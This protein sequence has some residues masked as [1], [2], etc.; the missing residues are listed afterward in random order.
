MFMFMFICMH[1]FKEVSH[2]IVKAKMFPDLVVC[3]SRSSRKAHGI[4]SS[5]KG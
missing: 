5:T 2:A 4:G 1:S 3:P